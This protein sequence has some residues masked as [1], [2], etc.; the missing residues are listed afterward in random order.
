MAQLAE[1]FLLSRLS[2]SGFIVLIAVAATSALLGE[3][4]VSAIAAA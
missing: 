3:P 2:R 4:L 1:K